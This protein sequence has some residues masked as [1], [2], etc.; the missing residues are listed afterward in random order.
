MTYNRGQH[1]PSVWAG[2]RVSEAG[3]AIQSALQLLGSVTVA[4]KQPETLLYYSDW[5]VVPIKL[6]RNRQW[7]RC[8]LYCRGL[9]VPDLKENYRILNRKILSRIGVKNKRFTCKSL[10][11]PFYVFTDL[12]YEMCVDYKKETKAIWVL[13]DTEPWEKMQ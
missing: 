10:S 7:A 11:V 12:L 13:K 9:P 5:V 6:Y 3:S 2:Q 1:M 4:Q 8:G